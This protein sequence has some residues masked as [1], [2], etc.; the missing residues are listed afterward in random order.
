MFFVQMF[1]I[2]QT[3]EIVPM[4]NKADERKQYSAGSSV[5]KPTEPEAEHCTAN[6]QMAALV[7]TLQNTKTIVNHEDTLE[8]RHCDE[9]YSSQRVVLVLHQTCF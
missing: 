9:R 4:K 7:K 3:S 2:L 6:S 8:V 1:L 5:Q